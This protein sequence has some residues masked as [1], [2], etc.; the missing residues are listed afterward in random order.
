MKRT[1]PN[2]ARKRGLP[3]Q[4]EREGKRGTVKGCPDLGITDTPG[5]SVCLRLCTGA[6]RRPPSCQSKDT[7]T[8]VRAKWPGGPFRQRAYMCWGPS[9]VLRA[10]G[11]PVTS[12]ERGGG[13]RD[14]SGDLGPWWHLC[15]GSALWPRVG[16]DAH[17]RHRSVE[18][19][20]WRHPG[21]EGVPRQ[22][23]EKEKLH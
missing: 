3:L 23:L 12:A 4:A 10:S 13:G 19:V 6:E 9:R 21:E 22:R 7:R 15:R 14:P 8:A 1:R 18:R 16:P 11:A 17:F 2:W 20:F 5:G